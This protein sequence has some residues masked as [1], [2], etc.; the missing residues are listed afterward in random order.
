MTEEQLRCDEHAVR[1]YGAS[2]AGQVP[3]VLEQDPCTLSGILEGNSVML[4]K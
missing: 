2:S 1:D 3:A 4:E